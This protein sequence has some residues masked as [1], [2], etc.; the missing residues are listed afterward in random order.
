MHTFMQKYS[1]LGGRLVYSSPD[2]ARD[3]FLGVAD[4]Q[5]MLQDNILK[6]QSTRGLYWI[7]GSEIDIRSPQFVC[8][9]NT[10][11]Q[12]YREE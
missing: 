7:F 11:V 9:V 4:T 10:Q 2:Y 8:A 3:H 6:I 12:P 5:H 1:Y